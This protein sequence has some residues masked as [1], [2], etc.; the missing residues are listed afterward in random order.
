MLGDKVDYSEHETKRGGIAPCPSAYLDSSNNGLT[1]YRELLY[2]P[3]N[4]AGFVR[5]VHSVEIDAIS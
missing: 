3:M 5:N 4:F 1:E 2:L